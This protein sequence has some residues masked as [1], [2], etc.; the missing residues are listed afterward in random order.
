MKTIAI[1][2]LLAGVIGATSALPAATTTFEKALSSGGAIQLKADDTLTG[3]VVI[4]KDTVLRGAGDKS[5]G[6]STIKLGKGESI[7]VAPGAT[8]TLENFDIQSADTKTPSII[9]SEGAAGNFNKVTIVA[10]IFIA[11]GAMPTSLDNIQSNGLDQAISHAGNGTLTVTNSQF[12]NSGLAA[13]N[14]A[15]SASSTSMTLNVSNC[16]FTTGSNFAIL[17]NKPTTATVTSSTFSGFPQAIG[18]P[19]NLTATGVTFTNNG[20]YNINLSKSGATRPRATI[21]GS[22]FTGG[23]Y[24]VLLDNG[25]A[26]ISNTDFTG[27]EQALAAINGAGSQAEPIVL[28]GVTMTNISLFGF[29]S[30]AGGYV[31]VT[32]G[33]YTKIKHPFELEANTQATM[34]GTV[35]NASN[36]ALPGPAVVMRGGSGGTF[37]NMTVTGHLNSFDAKEG[38]TLTVKNSHMI[39]PEFSG[40]I[41]EDSSVATVQNN[42]FTSNGQDGI[43]I[44]TAAA[45]D[46][47][48][49][50]VE[51]NIIL[52]SGVGPIDNA[53]GRTSQA[54]SGIAL[55]GA[56]PFIVRG[57]EVGRSFDAGI[58]NLGGTAGTILENNV[59]Y[60]NLKA[61]FYLQDINGIIVRDNMVVAQTVTGQAGLSLN[62]VTNV[63]FS[64]NFVS[65]N[66]YGVIAGGTESGVTH[67][68]SVFLQNAVQG[69]SINA[70]TQTVTNS[71]FLNNATSSYQVFVNSAGQS[72]FSNCSFS[73]ANK[74]GLYTNRGSCQAPSGLRTTALNNYWNNA[75]GP[76][77]NCTGASPDSRMEYQNA[78]VA[79]FL[80]ASKTEVFYSGDTLRSISS[81][82]LS[83]DATA[84]VSA[85]MPV[86]SFTDTTLGLMRLAASISETAPAGVA[87]PRAIY[88]WSTGPLKRMTSSNVTLRFTMPGTPT[89][90]KFSHY[91]RTSL[92][93]DSQLNV[94]TDAGFPGKWIV[95]ASA[96]KFVGGTW[97]FQG[98]VVPPSTKY[99]DV[100]VLTPY[101][102]FWSAQGLAGKTFATP[103]RWGFLGYKFDKATKWQTL[104]ADFSGDGLDDVGVV[105]QYGDF[106]TAT[107]NGAA[108]YSTNVK[109]STGWKFDPDAGWRTFPGDFNGDGK[110]DL[111]MI[112]QYTDKV[113]VGLNS[114][115]VVQP[116]SPAGALGFQYRPLTGYWIGVA[117]MNGDGRDD[118]V[119]Q[120]P[121]GDTWIALANVSGAFGAATKWGS[122]GFKWDMVNHAG[123]VLG[124][125]NGDGKADLLQVTQYG[126]VWVAPST[127]SALG[128]GTRWAVLGFKDAYGGTGNATYTAYAVDVD[129]DGKDDILDLT[130]YG[131]LWGATSTGSGFGAPTKYAV[132]GFH[133]NVI[134]GPWQTFFGNFSNAGG[135]KSAEADSAKST[136]LTTPRATPAPTPAPTPTPSLTPTPEQ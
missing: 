18:G 67:T 132:L 72:V 114:G 35:I 58:V 14:I 10:T 40:V 6:I 31:N 88:L 75:A 128:A 93:F 9:V 123:L 43:F 136:S 108:G 28:N 68:A 46:H 15:Y 115:G 45:S 109:Q 57:N 135:S 83:A 81:S 120:V 111:L 38:A 107:N 17:V 24:G 50:L 134:D 54:G 78:D 47:S 82:V 19:V 56:G 61:G 44:G 131:E 63:A 26:N 51:N 21:S 41:A 102:D 101:T 116:P 3:G 39:S 110:A 121:S 11:L 103:L 53:I 36:V 129:K 29:L 79:P 98:S 64:R 92:K 71:A 74:L 133:N 42:V 89:N 87:D 91:N 96:D 27:L 23:T 49:G 122:N 80:T 117:D 85:A 59:I 90:I 60:G 77:N 105:T 1:S 112:T 70:G 62:N 65:N 94:T 13:L 130:E 95:T 5:T 106:W 118:V 55:T 76:K 86:A 7:T 48:T 20:T 125:F 8:L 22:H 16:A 34:T 127:G 37:D 69:M 124:D 12:L 25:F 66:N 30:N 84:W 33:T 4:T 119:Q 104:T 52:D 32:N 99:I 113:W 97:Y 100:G 73:A 2:M 126:D